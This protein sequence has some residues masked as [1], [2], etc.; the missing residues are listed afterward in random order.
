MLEQLKE[1]QR[2]GFQFIVQTG[3]RD[4]LGVI[5]KTLLPEE[6]LYWDDFTIVKYSETE[7]INIRVIRIKQIHETIAVFS[8]SKY[9][10]PCR[11]TQ[12]CIESRN[13]KY[14]YLPRPEE[15]PCQISE[16]IHDLVN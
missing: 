1:Y 12:G 7:L 11:M 2:Q 13:K 8:Y 5:C 15:L 14:T 6:V 4:D 3:D 16:A 10:E 9:P